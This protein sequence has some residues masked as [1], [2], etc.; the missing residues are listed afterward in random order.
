MGVAQHW[1]DL[2]QIGRVT[3]QVS[4]VL[5]TF[6]WDGPARIAR[7]L[8][9]QGGDFVRMFA[10]KPWARLSSGAHD[11]SRW[12]AAEGR[13]EISEPSREPGDA[14]GGELRMVD[15]FS[16]HASEESC[17][18]AVE[19]KLLV[20]RIHVTRIY[21]AVRPESEWEEVPRYW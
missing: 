6:G 20:I 16:R 18:R 1:V 14:V 17:Q 2:A 5:R 8:G 19:Q 10:G 11:D 4:G 3:S 21:G 15:P 7:L 12:A 9:E 13:V